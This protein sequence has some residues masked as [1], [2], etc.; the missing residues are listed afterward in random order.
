M[1][2]I[3]R[4][5]SINT[6]TYK[7][8]DGIDINIIEQGM[9]ADRGNYNHI[10]LIKYKEQLYLFGGKYGNKYNTYLGFQT[11][12]NELKNYDNN[13]FKLFR[14]DMEFNSDKEDMINDL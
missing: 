4:E 6:W 11:N 8:L 12:E 7:L 2:A 14:A 5:N 10:Y 9:K 3:D 13:L 1:I